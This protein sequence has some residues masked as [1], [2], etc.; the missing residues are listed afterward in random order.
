VARAELVKHPDK[1]R[2]L[3]LRPRY[4]LLIETFA[5]CLLQRGALQGQVLIISGDPSVTNQHG[6]TGLSRISS[7]NSLFSRQAFVTWK[8]QD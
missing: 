7:Q 4:L 1:L 3:T 5:H 6:E 2:A 8:S